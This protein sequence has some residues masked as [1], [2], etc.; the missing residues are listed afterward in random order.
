MLDTSIPV[1]TPAIERAEPK[2]NI[3]FLDAARSPSGE[4]DVVK[5]SALPIALVAA[6]V[7]V[8]AVLL[9]AILLAVRKRKGGRSVIVEENDGNA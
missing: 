2:E 8:L 3:A 5:A 6:G 9:A 1:S 4:A 7:A